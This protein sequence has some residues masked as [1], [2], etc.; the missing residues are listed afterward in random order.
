[1]DFGW[2]AA[3]VLQAFCQAGFGHG[4]LC[5]QLAEVHADWVLKDDVVLICDQDVMNEAKCASLH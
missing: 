2:L 4:V 3:F 1:M 5:Q